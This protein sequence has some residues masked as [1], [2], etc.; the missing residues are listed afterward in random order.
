MRDPH[1]LATRAVRLV[2]SHPL[3]RWVGQRAYRA[4]A[5]AAGSAL[6]PIP[7]VTAVYLAGSAT[8]PSRIDPGH[9]DLDLVLVTELGDVEEELRMREALRRRLRAGRALVPALHQADYVDAVDL[10]LL[11]RFPNA[12]SMG[13]DERWERLAGRDVRLSVAPAI[14]ARQRRLEPLRRSLRRWTKATVVLRDPKRPD[15]LRNA[16]RLYADVAAAW[17]EADRLAPLD[18]LSTRAGHPDASRRGP[19]ALLGAALTLLERFALE[20]APVGAAP[21][22]VEGTPPSAPDLEALDRAAGQA[23]LGPVVVGSRDPCST[24]RVVFVRAPAGCDA[25]DAV[26]RMTRVAAASAPG[27]WIDHPVLLTAPLWR[28]GWLLDVPPFA[29][30]SLALASPDDPPPAP[31]REDLE[32][33]LPVLLVERLLR[34]RGRGFRLRAASDPLRAAWREVRSLAPALEALLDGGPVVFRD[35]P[36]RLPGEAELLEATRALSDRLHARYP[37]GGAA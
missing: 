22:A 31:A 2:A 28:A 8:R 32:A 10:S 27:G 20:V 4:V 5:R 35:A 15:A 19:V 9:S 37:A 36:S 25:E 21:F 14:D 7:G 3:G 18:V 24:D 6:A 23:G 12:W 1:A 17:L 16:R 26:A 33:I 30:A 34:A 29:G 13:F 11:R